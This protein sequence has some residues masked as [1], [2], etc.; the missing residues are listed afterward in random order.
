MAAYDMA[1]T[2]DALAAKVLAAG[3]STNVYAY[4][5]E[6]VQVPC[7]VVGYPTS[8]DFDRTF[9]RGSDRA[10]H[11]IFFLTGRANTKAA[12]DSLSDVLAAATG[13]KDTL[14]G[15][16]TVGD[17]TA[18]VRVTDGTVEE[19]TVSGVPYLAA[20]FTVEVLS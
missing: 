4:P 14:D 13:I 3:I 12:R 9:A 6:T 17:N 16:L 8:I 20:R 1:R 18:A 15:D 10:V 19:V 11:P 5:A 7:V 2:M